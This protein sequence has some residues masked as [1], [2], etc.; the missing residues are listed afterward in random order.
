MV[1]NTPYITGPSQESACWGNA[2]IRA[3]LRNIKSITLFKN[4]F[5]VYNIYDCK[6]RLNLLNRLSIHKHNCNFKGWCQ[7]FLYSLPV[8]IPTLFCWHVL[9]SNFLLRWQSIQMLTLNI[10]SYQTQLNSSYQLFYIQ[11]LKVT[12]YLQLQNNSV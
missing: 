5:I 9:V 7:Q 10:C 3:S 2:L 1:N 6:S 8:I 11:F 12:L 4:F